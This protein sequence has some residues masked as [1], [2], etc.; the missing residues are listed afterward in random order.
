MEQMLKNP[1]PISVLMSVYHGEKPEY[2][3]QALQSIADQGCAPAEVVLVEDGQ[4][5]DELATVIDAYEASLPLV[6]LKFIKNR[7]LGPSLRDGLEACAH[8]IVARMDSDDIA[9][10]SRFCLQYEYIE[11]NGIDLLGSFIEEFNSKPGDLGVVRSLPS[12]NEEICS[13]LGRRN[14]FNHMTVMFRK[15]KVLAAGSYRDEPYFEDYGLWLRMRRQGSKFANMPE[16]HV[17]ARIGDGFV[18]RRSGLKYIKRE[19]LALSSF[20][21]QGLIGKRDFLF[22]IVVR[23]AVR[24]LPQKMFQQ[25]YSTVLRRRAN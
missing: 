3:R 16:V 20:H 14:C 18:A 21:Q 4:I 10:Q 1:L 19:I 17:D 22:G 24:T 15:S 13:K 5:P 12:Q 9:R 8:E 7:G 6:R 2:L 25:L 11:K 23:T